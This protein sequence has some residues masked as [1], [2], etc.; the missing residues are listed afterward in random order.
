MPIVHDGIPK[1]AASL[2][3]SVP[4]HLFR[5]AFLTIVGV[6]CGVAVLLFAG[7]MLGKSLLKNPIKTVTVDRTPP[8]VMLS[9]K[10]LALYKAASGNYEVLVD[11][12]KDVKY[13]P[14]ALA[15]SRTLFIGVGSVDATVDFRNL[16]AA[17]IV[18]SEDRTSATITL[19]HAGL[20]AATV[21]PVQSHVAARDRGIL[22]RLSGAVSD[23]SDSDRELYI[24]A[25]QKMDAAATASGLQAKAEANTTQ[26][27]TSLLQHL[28]YT[29]VEI[30]F[31]GAAPTGDI[32]SSEESP[33]P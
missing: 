19:P 10:D 13:I 32:G 21:D 28:G 12:E 27:L 29:H 23:S 25:A 14:K 24:A 16:N 7:L 2:Q 8:P 3:Q 9:L 31:D 6:C 15:G 30:K 5:K 17:N 18:T 22:D 33:K 26:M 11:V 20:S 1:S 4:S